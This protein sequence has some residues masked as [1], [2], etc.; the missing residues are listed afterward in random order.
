[1][2][3]GSVNTVE[4]IASSLVS[5]DCMTSGATSAENLLIL[6]S[7]LFYPTECTTRLFYIKTYIKIYIKKLLHVSVNKPSSGSLLLCFAEVM[8]IKTVS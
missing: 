7:L 1:M 8:I 6:S 5:I 4:D 3:Q 2:T